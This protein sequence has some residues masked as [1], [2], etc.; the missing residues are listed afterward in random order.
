MFRR[1]KKSGKISWK[2]YKNKLNKS[3]PAEPFNEYER[4]LHNMTMKDNEF[5]DCLSS[6]EYAELS[7]DLNI[8]DKT[9]P[10]YFNYEKEL[11]IEEF[12]N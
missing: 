12:K 1:K 7:D 2:E 10:D 5:K 4:D 11:I 6:K 8:F 3:E 9:N